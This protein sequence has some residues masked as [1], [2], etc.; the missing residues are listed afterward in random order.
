MRR[1]QDRPLIGITVGTGLYWRRGG[2]YYRSYASAVESAGG[3]CIPLGL[4]ASMRIERCAGLLVPGGWDV[5]PSHYDLLPGD[6]GLSIDELKKKYRI[7]C[8]RRRDDSELPLIRRALELGLPVL[9][10]C[11]GIQSLNVVMARRLVP[12]IASCVPNALRHRS[13][14]PAM[15]FSH[16]I[17]VEPGSLIE[18]V[19]GTTTLTVNTR[20]HQGILP[21]MVPACLRVAAMAP[22]GVVEAVESRDSRFIVG[23]Q[24]HPERKTD[25]YIHEISGPLF[26]AFVDACR[27]HAGGRGEGLGPQAPARVVE[28]RAPIL[29]PYS[30]CRKGERR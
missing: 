21:E 29:R 13:T 24:W 5:H 15:S 27:S 30:A 10:I 3:S 28:S 17:E 26:Q 2:A 4:H 23:V 1:E 16:P 12:D 9:A 19:Y 18:R 14:G 11:R 20:H 8:E 22:D 7:K 25:T 6:E